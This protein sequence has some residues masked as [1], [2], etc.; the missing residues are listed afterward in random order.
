MI[1]RR[2]SVR[3][4]LL[5]GAI[6]LISLLAIG[7]II[8][9]NQPSTTSENR[10]AVIFDF[11]TG[12]PL[13]AVA[14]STPFNQTSKGI[15]ALFSS[16]SD[17]AA[18]S[19]TSYDATGLKL[20]QFSGKYLY[21]SK[22]SRDILDIEFSTDIIA[23]K[24]TFATVETQGEAITLPS[25]IDVTAYKNTILVGNN[26]TQGSFSGDS[27]P[28]GTLSLSTSKQPFNWVRISIPAQTSGTTDFLIDNIVVTTVSQ[29][30]TP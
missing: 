19:A 1:G 6:V 16:P 4:L 14:Q 11:D 27:Y 5:V 21:D 7:Y 13:L 8:Q 17:P 9:T 15:T 18:F 22:Q 3:R 29:T 30:T 10:P 12:S 23:V 28:Q 20:S 2:L 24:F 25:N 26:R